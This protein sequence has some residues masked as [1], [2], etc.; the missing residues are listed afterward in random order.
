MQHA[1][2]PRAK[3][4]AAAGYTLRS[5]KSNVAPRLGLIKKVVVVG[6]VVALAGVW[7]HSDMRL[8]NAA[9]AICDVSHNQ[10]SG[11]SEQACADAL[12][13]IDAQ[14]VCLQVN[15]CEVVR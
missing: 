5:D 14:Y 15:D 4:H 9:Q 8:V 1:Q 3:R 11:T 10:I 7:W 12:D 13:K 2:T 6:V